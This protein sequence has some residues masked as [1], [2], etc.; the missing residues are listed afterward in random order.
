MMVALFVVL[1]VAAYLVGAA[2]FS[3]IVGRLFYG[4]DVREHGS[5]NIGTTNVFR[6]LGKKAGVVVFAFDLLK[7]FVPALVASMLFDPWFAIFIAAAPVVGHMYSV[8][9]RF[10]GGKGV[11]TGSGVVLALEPTV[12]FI[13]LAGWIAIVLATRMVSLASI[14]AAVSLPVLIILWGDPLPYQ[15]AAVLVAAVVVYAHRGN[16]GR[17]LNGTEHRVTLPWGRGGRHGAGAGEA[18]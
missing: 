10:R 12:F 15:I 9:L 4:V 7:G 14:A 13:I 16:I 17:I 5:G 3:L 2:P 18:Q 1:L 11:A 8:F 6:V